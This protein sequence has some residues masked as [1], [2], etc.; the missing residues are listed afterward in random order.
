[1]ISARFPNRL[2]DR[3]RPRPE[4]IDR[5]T[6]ARGFELDRSALL[7]G[8]Q[9]H[10]AVCSLVLDSFG[11]CRAAAAFTDQFPAAAVGIAPAGTKLSRATGRLDYL[12]RGR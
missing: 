2:S 10:D 12:P 5:R 1:M 7:W 8:P 4:Y 3:R 11:Y 6:G 9:F